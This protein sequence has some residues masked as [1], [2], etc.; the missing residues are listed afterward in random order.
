IE[1]SY[2][3]VGGEYSF[4]LDGLIDLITELDL[5]DRP[6]KWGSIIGRPTAYPPAPHIHDIGDSYGWEYVVWQLERITYAILVG[7][8][9]SHEELRTQMRTLHDMQQ[10]IIDALNDRFVDH[11]NDIDNPHSVTKAQVGLGEVD[12]FPTA[13]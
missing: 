13:S 6:I 1:M 2:Q 7:D 10:A 8:E 3:V 9:A 11:T 4:N 5:D 12:N